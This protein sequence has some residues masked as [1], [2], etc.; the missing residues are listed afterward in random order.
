[1]ERRAFMKAAGL[2][3]LGLALGPKTVSAEE[4]SARIRWGL[5]GTGK[6]CWQHVKV[7]QRFPESRIVA[8]CD[9]Q[10]DRLDHA[11]EMCK[12]DPT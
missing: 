1:M 4:P 9:I 3:A 8:L 7:L 5:V 11:M 12:A 10:K 6:R 2:G